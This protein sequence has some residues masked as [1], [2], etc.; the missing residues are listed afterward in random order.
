[1][2]KQ[3]N[4]V[5]GKL[6]HVQTKVVWGTRS[7]GPYISNIANIAEQEFVI[8]V[9][10]NLIH[11]DNSSMHN[12]KATLVD[13]QYPDVLQ[14]TVMSVSKDSKYLATG[15]KM[16]GAEKSHINILIYHISNRFHESFR[17]RHIHF[18]AKVPFDD[19]HDELEIVSIAF[20]HD[21]Q[22]LAVAVNRADVG[23]LIFDQVKGSLFQT[24]VTDAVPLS[25]SFHPSDCS[26]VCITGENNLVRFWRYTAKSAHLAPVVG[27][28]RGY[29]SYSCH[30]WLA[31]NTETSVVVGSTSGF[32][33]PIQNCE[34]RAPAHQ[35]FG[36]ADTYYP[37]D[38]AICQ[39]LVKSDNVIVS[40]PKGRV[41]LYELRR[42]MLSKGTG[43]VATLVPLAFYRI[44]G[45]DCMNGLQFISR[46][47]VTS[48]GLVACCGESVLQL[49]LITDFDL[50]GGQIGVKNGS[51]SPVASNSPNSK[52]P[53]HAEESSKVVWL[54]R[55]A[56][57]SL[58]KFHSKNI[59]TL[60]MAS[61]SRCFLTGSYED[62][63]LR[64][65]DFDQ[66]STFDPCWLIESFADRPAE[67]PFHA[68][69]HPSGLQLAVATE[70]EV[71]EY[72]ISD[73][74]LD[75]IRRFSVRTP[76]QGTSGV[77]VVVTQPVSF[78][79]YSNGGHLLAVVTGKIAQIFHAYSP[80][81]DMS[82]PGGMSL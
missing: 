73:N 70:T 28:R 61:R 55:E 24:L 65:W 12:R 37:N 58:F 23:V 71:R 46:D 4:I 81:F 5:L 63:T 26:K 11:M 44:K 31:P 41:V 27:L 64:I 76:F 34:Q 29:H 15:V 39:I 33:V 50:S 13:S 66:P 40:S 72:A 7:L 62:A 49:D 78:V 30:G 77:P 16:K 14:V 75:L 69:L 17:P 59:N 60:S 82:S 32:I 25:T 48:F 67:N 45:V 54:E 43:L 42:V 18:T 21:S 9:G 53:D 6:S 8:P 3:H 22:Y 2:S 36:E 51:S 38:N 47:S 52:H 74:S 56:K 10:C 68:D 35:A 1:M 19:H 79:R 20:S 57:R 80:E